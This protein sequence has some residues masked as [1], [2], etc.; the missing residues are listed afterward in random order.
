MDIAKDTFVVLEYTV[1]LEDGSF[2]K[3]ENGPVSLNFVV[4]YGQVLPAL[5]ER[6]LGLEAGTQTEFVIPARWAFGNHDASQMHTRTFEEFP[7]GRNL[8]PGK[9]VI[10]TNEKTEAQYSFFVK[11]KTEDSVTLD[12]NHPLAGKDLHYRVK[13]VHLRPA[14]QEELEYLEPC[15]HADENSGALTQ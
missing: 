14:L 11:D 10:A 4:G 5:E 13:I 8:Q 6:L 1:Q 9:W 2:I 12:F 7:E 15:K 3:G